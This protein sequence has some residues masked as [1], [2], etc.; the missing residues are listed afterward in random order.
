[1]RTLL[2]GALAATLVGCSC[3][4]PPQTGMQACVDLNGSPC[5]DGAVASQPIEPEPESFKAKSATRRTKTAIAA[6][7]EKTSSD[8]DR[9]KPGRA[10][11]KVKFTIAAAKIEPPASGQA[12]EPPPNPV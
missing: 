11:G 4:L 7:P 5:F 8:D 6:K 2:V 1:M 9:D 3:L 10:V 12:T